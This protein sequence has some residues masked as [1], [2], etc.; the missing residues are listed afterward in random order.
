MIELRILSIAPGVGAGRAQ[1]LIIMQTEHPHIWE[2]YD[3]PPA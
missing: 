3:N 1:G 2:P